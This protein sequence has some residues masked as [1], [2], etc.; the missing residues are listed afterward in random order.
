V[1]SIRARMNAIITKNLP[2]LAETSIL[3]ISYLLLWVT[4]VDAHVAWA[5]A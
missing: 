1:A 4:G 3:D 5:Y 2:F